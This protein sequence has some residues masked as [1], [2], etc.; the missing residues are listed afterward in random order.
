MGYA[1]TS[2]DVIARDAGVT[3]ATYYLHFPTKAAVFKAVLDDLVARLSD[4][5]R[6]VDLTVDAPT[7]AAQLTSED[8]LMKS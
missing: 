4:A 3:R 2:P 8:S 5:V 1:A 7:P 6:G